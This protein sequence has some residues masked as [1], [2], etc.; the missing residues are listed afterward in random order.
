MSAGIVPG[1]NGV[2]IGAGATEFTLIPLSI[3]CPANDL[4]KA[5]DAP[6]V[7]EYATSFP[8]PANALTDIVLTIE[9]PSL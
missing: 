3:T 7:D 6:L 2:Q 5:S 8:R 4:V 1:M 9:A